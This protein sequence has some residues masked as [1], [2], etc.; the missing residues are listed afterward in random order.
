MDSKRLAVAFGLSA[1]ILILWTLVFP[2][3]KPAPRVPVSPKPTVSAAAAPA[4]PTAVP[5][6]S[7]AAEPAAPAAVPPVGATE[8]REVTL[9][10]GVLTL[11]L[12][13]RGGEVVSAE[14]SRFRGADEKGALEL[15]RQGRAVRRAD[16]RLRPERSVPLAG[17]RRAARDDGRGGG[18]GDG[19]PLP[20]PRGGRTGGGSDL[21]VRDRVRSGAE[22][23]EGGRQ[24]SPGR[25]RPRPRSRQPVEGRAREPLHEAGFERHAF[26]DP[27]GVEESEGRPEGARARRFGTHRRR[28]RRQLLRHGLPAW[29]GGDA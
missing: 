14:L 11:K 13:N 15:V 23:R 2:A 3:P 9:K 16:R 28:T 20:L 22:G 24:R 29:R 7:A 26:G 21:H 4:T 6:V 17:R 19:R 27:V 18:E 5:E 12:S 8:P 25:G 1:A 10:N